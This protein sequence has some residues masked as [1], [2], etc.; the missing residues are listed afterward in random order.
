[1]AHV[2][3]VELAKLIETTTGIESQYGEPELVWKHSVAFVELCPCIQVAGKYRLE[4]RLCERFLDW[5][6]AGRVAIWD[7]LLRSVR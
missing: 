1:M 5:F 4:V 7:W 3:G 2:L 6:F